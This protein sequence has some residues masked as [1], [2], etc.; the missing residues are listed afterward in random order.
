MAG[1][2]ERF[3]NGW[4]GGEVQ[5]WLGGRRGS[6]MAGWGRGSMTQAVAGR[7]K[8]SAMAEREER[9]SWRI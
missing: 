5:Q 6:A 3:S 8:D 7:E 2:E 4:E 9:S 1:R